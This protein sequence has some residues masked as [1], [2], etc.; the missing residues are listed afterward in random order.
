MESTGA[1][2]KFKREGSKDSLPLWSKNSIGKGLKS[3][4][5]SLVTTYAKHEFPNLAQFTSD[6][7]GV[8]GSFGVANHPLKE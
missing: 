7:K 5:Y 6:R 4:D 2:S 1:M 3:R 8:I